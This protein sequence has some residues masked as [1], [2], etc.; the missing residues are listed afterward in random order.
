MRINLSFIHQII[1]E[2][3]LEAPVTLTDQLASLIFLSRVLYEEIDSPTNVVTE[4]VTE[5]SATV[6][7]EPVRAVIDKYVVRYTS[8]G[9]ETRD[10]VVPREQSSTV[11]TGLRPGEA[12]RVHVWAE[13]GS[14]ESK[15]ADTTALTGEGGS[16]GRQPVSSL[17]EKEPG[18]GRPP[19]HSALLCESRGQGSKAI[20][21]FIA[22]KFFL[23]KP[24]TK[25]TTSLLSLFDPEG[26]TCLG[27]NSIRSF[28][29]A[30]QHF[31][32]FS[33]WT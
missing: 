7:W 21:N 26:H 19:G 28:L 4:R 9:G 30:E 13:R 14:Q 12:Y 11:L 22:M 1:N 8:A 20:S 5:D 31:L 25:E 6:S 16:A 24:Q 3:D 10:T 15:K 32:I 18:G 29:Q 17:G 23:F 2:L 33:F 27:W